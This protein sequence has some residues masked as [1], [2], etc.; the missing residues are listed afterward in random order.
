MTAADD[1]AIRIYTSKW[2]M[3]GLAIPCFFIAYAGLDGLATGALAR[4]SLV[5]GMLMAIGIGCGLVLLWMAFEKQPVLVID[6]RGITCRRPPTGLIPWSAVAGLGL[7]K[8]SIIRAV[9]LVAIDEPSAHGPLGDRLKRYKASTF[10]SPTVA[11]FQGQMKG[12]TTIQIPIS[13]LD[14]KR[15]ALQRMLEERVHF[16]G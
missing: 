8:V 9:L 3:G 2:K 1:D 16:A 6:R 7:G 12:N 13:L 4:S 11:R 14:V 10:F 5:D 15:E